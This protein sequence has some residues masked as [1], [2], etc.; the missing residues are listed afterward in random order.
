ME[1]TDRIMVILALSLYFIV[2]FMAWWEI[3]RF[4]GF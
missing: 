1:K 2:G 3:E 4:F